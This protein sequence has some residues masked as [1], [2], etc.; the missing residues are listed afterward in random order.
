MDQRTRC[1][2]VIRWVQ[3]YTIM[4]C[5]S[6]W[7]RGSTIASSLMT[8][9]LV[10]VSKFAIADEALNALHQYLEKKNAAVNVAKIK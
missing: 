1:S 4:W 7:L 10:I 3:L 5:T 2:S 8:W 9:P 6:P